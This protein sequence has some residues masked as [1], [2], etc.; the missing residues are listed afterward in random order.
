VSELLVGDI[1]LVESIASVDGMI[2]PCENL[3]LSETHTIRSH[4]QSQDSKE[5]TPSGTTTAQSYQHLG[6]LSTSTWISWVVVRAEYDVSGED[7]DEWEK[8]KG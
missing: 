7:S 1:F 5:K 3:M 4:I 8:C 2:L 6:K